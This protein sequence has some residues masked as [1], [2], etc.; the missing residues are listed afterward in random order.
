MINTGLISDKVNKLCRAVRKDISSCK[1]LEGEAS[2]RFALSGAR[3]RDNVCRKDE[4]AFGVVGVGE[5]K[6]IEGEGGRDGKKGG[7]DGVPLR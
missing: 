1:P 5:C 7:D 4:R 6:V 3:A 2:T